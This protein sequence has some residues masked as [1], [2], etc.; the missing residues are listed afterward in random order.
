MDLE[1]KLCEQEK[2]LPSREGSFFRFMDAH[3]A[4]EALF[5]RH[6][7]CLV[8]RDLEEA[9]LLLKRYRAM[10]LRHMRDEEEILLPIY[11]KGQVQPGGKVHY[12]V[13]EHRKLLEFLDRIKDGMGVLLEA[14]GEAWYRALFAVLDLETTFKNIGEHHEAREE[15][16]LFPGLDALLDGKARADVL[17]R[18][19]CLQ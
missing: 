2:G 19:Q 13:Q 9:L 12:F 6:Q 17:A 11:E 16:F 18:C 10:L 5:H 3:E 7:C 8:D 15:K 4:Q 14:D 1:K